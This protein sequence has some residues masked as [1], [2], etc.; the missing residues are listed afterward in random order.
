ME[1]VRNNIRNLDNVLSSKNREIEKAARLLSKDVVE[2]QRVDMSAVALK[3]VDKA[4][5]DLN[6]LIMKES[7]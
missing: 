6:K 4:R 1:I 7:E 3:H 2:L 5:E